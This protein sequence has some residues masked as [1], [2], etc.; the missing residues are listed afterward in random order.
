MAHA[1]LQTPGHLQTAVE[2]RRRISQI[3]FEDLWVCDKLFD[4]AIQKG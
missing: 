1:M 4:L 2:R 3:L